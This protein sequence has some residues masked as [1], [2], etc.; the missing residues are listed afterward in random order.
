MMVVLIIS[1]FVMRL[2]SI[3]TYETPESSSDHPPTSF[4]LYLILNKNCILL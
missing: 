4:I 3:L 2:Y 1:D